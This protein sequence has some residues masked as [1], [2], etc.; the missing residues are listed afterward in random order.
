MTE[1]MARGGLSRPLLARYL[2]DCGAGWSLGTFGAI[3]EF[4][5]DEGE[6]C[7]LAADGDGPVAMTTDRGGIAI[8]PR[9]PHRAAAYETPAAR[10]PRW[11]HAVALCLPEEACAMN[12]RHA[13]TELGPDTGALRPRDREAILFDMGLGAPQADICVRT[14]DPEALAALRES[15]GRSALDPDNPLMGRMPAFSPHRV[16]VSRLGRLEVYQPIPPADG[17]S[18]QGPHTHVLP[19]VLASGRTHAATAPVPDGLVPCAHLFP[20]NPVKTIM[21]EPR[22]FDRAAHDGFQ[23]LLDAFGDARL[24]VV[25]R[26]VTEAVQAGEAPG[27]FTPPDD[28]FARA[29]VK[30]V[31][32]QLASAGTARADVLGAWAARFDPPGEE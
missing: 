28:R 7:T 26:S 18:P 9:L 19:K 31:L 16:F 27:S 15:E 24:L 13:V 6:P 30:V 29:A 1:T 10:T 2:E 22:P 4:M 21:G 3:G 25:K 14:S 32:R 5:H 8:D 20:A 11:N 12:R 23:A 17:T